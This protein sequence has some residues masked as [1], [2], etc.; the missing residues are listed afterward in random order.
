L[1]WMTP[2]RWRASD[3]LS[4]RDAPLLEDPLHRD[5]EL[6][7]IGRDRDARGLHGA[8]LVRGRALAAGD[9]RPGV[10]H[11]LARRRRAARDEAD[12]RLG[13]VLLD[14]GGGSLLGVAADLADHDDGLRVGVL[15][16]GLQTVDEVGPVQRV[17]A[18]AHGGRLP[19]AELGELVHRLV[20]EG[21]RA[22]DDADRA[23][24]VDMTRHD[25]DLAAALRA[26]PSS[27]RD[28]ARAVGTDE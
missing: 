17:A 11:A 19:G 5:A 8:D 28:D 7:R 20:G 1:P 4:G 12:H 22:G 26:L 24:P 23:S 14:V 27:G 13:D 6:R 16:E 25:A 10:P 21:A 18:D 15:L 3:R 9:D 2:Y